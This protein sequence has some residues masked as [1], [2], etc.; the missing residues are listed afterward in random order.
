LLSA[1]AGGFDVRNVICRNIE[2]TPE[3]HQ[4]RKIDKRGFAHGGPF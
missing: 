4:A 1:K 3:N 2:S